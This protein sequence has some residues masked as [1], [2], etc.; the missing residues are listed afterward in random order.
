MLGNLSVRDRIEAALLDRPLGSLR[1]LGELL[2]AI[3]S[4]AGLAACVRRWPP[5]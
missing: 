1:E 4:L 5:A 2:A 3:R